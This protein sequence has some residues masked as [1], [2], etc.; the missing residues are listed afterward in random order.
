MTN[1]NYI[2]NNRQEA[3]TELT[4][5]VDEVLHMILDLKQDKDV[6]LYHMQTI[7]LEMYKNELD[8]IDTVYQMDRERQKKTIRDITIPKFMIK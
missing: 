8:L 3:K 2:C 6:D 4:A 5:K 7:I 1:V